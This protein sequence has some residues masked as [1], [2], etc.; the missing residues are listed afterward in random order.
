MNTEI[1]RNGEDWKP[2]VL[3][4]GGAVG[5][6]AGLIAAY[7]LI[8]RAERDNTAPEIKARE[9]VKLGFLLFGLLRE[10]AALGDGK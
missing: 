5:L 4:V 8:Q 3:L 6:A 2:K 9:G 7:L 10:I 1:M